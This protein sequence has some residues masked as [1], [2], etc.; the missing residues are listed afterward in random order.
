M[1]DF[2]YII[3]KKRDKDKT[4]YKEAKIYWI[5]NNNLIYLCGTTW[6]KK[7]HSTSENEVLEALINCNYLQKEALYSNKINLTEINNTF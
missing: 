5:E 3:R 7:W 6:R 1:E 4:I 2:A